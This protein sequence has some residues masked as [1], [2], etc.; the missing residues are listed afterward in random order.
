MVDI[1]GRVG[2][3]SDAAMLIN[4]M[5]AQPAVLA[6]MTLIGACQYHLEIAVVIPWQMNMADIEFGNAP[7]DTIN[8]PSDAHKLDLYWGNGTRLNVIIQAILSFEEGLPQSC[9]VTHEL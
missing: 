7:A 5:P 2:Q 8:E 3:L 1:L 9:L 4:L 6:F